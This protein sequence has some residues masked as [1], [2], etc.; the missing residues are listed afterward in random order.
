MCV[1][2]CFFTEKELYYETMFGKIFNHCEKKK[3]FNRASFRT[4]R[5]HTI[6]TLSILLIFEQKG[7]FQTMLQDKCIP[8]LPHC[9]QRCREY[10]P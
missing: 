5:S 8:W 3:K 1:R 7:A 10:A 4:T 2:K 9:S 6:L